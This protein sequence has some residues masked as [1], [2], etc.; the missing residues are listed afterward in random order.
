MPVKITESQLRNIVRQE[1]R[2]LLEA[3]TRNLSPAES[4]AAGRNHYLKVAIAAE[5]RAWLRDRAE[6]I[7]S[8]QHTIGKLQA[9]PPEKKIKPSSF[10]DYLQRI[11]S[12]LEI[13]QANKEYTS[14]V[15]GYEKPEKP[16]YIQ[17][18]P[19]LAQSSAFGRSRA[20]DES[21]KK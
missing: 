21:K 4:A 12:V 7:K 6:M 3:S 11:L 10:I 9:F 1:T 15:T 20:M 13:Q 17:D 18:V 5:K 19:G 16:V 2:K 8:I 14:D